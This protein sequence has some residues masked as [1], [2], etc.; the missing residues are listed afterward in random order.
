MRSKDSCKDVLLGLANLACFAPVVLSRS[1][2]VLPRV[3]AGDPLGDECLWAFWD[4]DLTGV[5][6][7]LIYP[8]ELR[9]F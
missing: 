4:E 9:P 5:R 8:G 1:E 7:M 3:S 2:S 6:S